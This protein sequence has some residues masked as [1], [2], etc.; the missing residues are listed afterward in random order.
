MPLVS[1]VVYCVLCCLCCMMFRFLCVCAVVVVVWQFKGV[2]LTVGIVLF[3]NKF[4]PYLSDL[5]LFRSIENV[6]VE[7]CVKVG[8]VLGPE[9]IQV[10]NGLA[11]L[12]G[13]DRSWFLGAGTLKSRLAGQVAQ[14]AIY[15]YD[16]QGVAGAA[17]K[18][19]SLAGYPA[20][21]GFHPHGLFV[22]GTGGGA[23]PATP[24]VFVVN[25]RGDGEVVS[26]FD[27]ASDG[28][29]LVHLADLKDPLFR[30][31]NDVVP[32]GDDTIYVTNWMCVGWGCGA[33]WRRG[34]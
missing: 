11:Y 13:D 25:H 24:R 20:H 30:N 26:V 10:V 1:G 17:P 15:T 29:T 3:V 12:T 4:L 31:I 8:G 2:V 5:G 34:V 19:L 28:D 27:A 18:Q 32:V 33:R 6:N 23:T 14:G 16:V 22:D 21:L 7:R 9:D